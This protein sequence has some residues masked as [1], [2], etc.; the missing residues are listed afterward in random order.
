MNGFG[1]KCHPSFKIK[2]PS[3]NPDMSMTF[4][5]DRSELILLARSMPDIPAIWIF[6]SIKWIVPLCSLDF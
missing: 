3:V 4:M 5:P 6:E 1:R 2:R